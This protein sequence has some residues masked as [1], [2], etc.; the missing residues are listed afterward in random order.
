M[1]VS[2]KMIARYRK[3][4]HISQGELAARLSEYGIRIAGKTVSNWEHDIS[5]PNVDIFMHVCRILEIPDLYEEYFGD[6][7]HNLLAQLNP[8]G[9]K[10]ALDYLQLLI[11]SGQYKK[12]QQA[13]AT[14]GKE[15]W[16]EKREEENASEKVLPISSRRKIR[17]FPT[18]PVS[19]GPGEFLEDTGYEMIEL[20]NIPRGADFVVRIHGDSML[21]DSEDGQRVFVHQT[22][23]LNNGE[24]GIF[25]VDGSG[26]IKKLSYNKDGVSLVSLNSEKYDPIPVLPDSF[27]MVFGRVIGVV[28]SH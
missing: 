15:D 20:D 28:P 18:L 22:R 4:R 11:E 3:M 6:N 17:F 9:K 13:A 12:D 10:K 5:S 14:A 7:P 24:I 1:S 27:F 21:P 26:Y 2:G 23:T 19:A 8:A 25:A 16:E